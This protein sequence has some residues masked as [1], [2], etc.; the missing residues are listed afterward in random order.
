MLD[1]LSN[2]VIA[3]FAIH[4]RDTFDHQVVALGGAAGKNNLFGSGADQRSDLCARIFNGFFSGPSKRVIAACGISKFFREVR[5]H[6][7]NDARIDLRGGVIIKINRQLDS[8]VSILLVQLLSP[9]SHEHLLLWF[10]TH[11]RNSDGV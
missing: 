1:G 3:F 10:V 8:H 11:L 4:F 2:N 6:R 7:L 9:Q 5:Q